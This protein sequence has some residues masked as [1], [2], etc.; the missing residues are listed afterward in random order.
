MKPGC[1]SHQNE[2]SE[3]TYGKKGPVPRVERI[4]KL[5]ECETFARGRVDRKF[6]NVPIEWERKSDTQ[7][8][9]EPPD[10]IAIQFHDSNPSPG[11]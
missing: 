7:G 5:V 9:R 8:V 3:E 4:L 11:G 2:T 10:Q 1:P 6:H